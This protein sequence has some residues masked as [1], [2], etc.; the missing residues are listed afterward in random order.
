M[1]VSI[2]SISEKQVELTVTPQN[3]IVNIV[4]GFAFGGSTDT[5]AANVG[6]GIGLYK[7]KVGS[8][9]QFKSLLEG[10]NIDITSGVNEVTISAITPTLTE[11][12]TSG[13]NAGGIVISNIGAPVNPSDAVRLQD[14][15]AVTGATGP[16]GGDLTGTYPD[17]TLIDIA[18]L[19]PGIY[20]DGANYAAVEVDA[21][22]RVIAIAEF[23]LPSTAATGPAGGDL[24]GTYP[25]PTIS[26]GAVSYSKLQAASADILLGRVG[27]AGTIQEIT[28]GPGLAFSG[29]A[30]SVLNPS[31]INWIVGGN[32]VSAASNLGT[33]SNF[34]LP[35]ITNNVERMRITA[36]GVIQFSGVTNDD[37][38]TRVLV[39]DGSGNMYYRNAGSIVSST[40]TWDL[41]G[42]TVTSLVNFGTI[43]NFDIPIVTNNIE[44]ARFT[45]D[46]NLGLGTTPSSIDRLSIVG[47]ASGNILKLRDSANTIDRLLITDAGVIT[48]TTPALN[49]TNTRILTQ[50]S[51]SGI[52]EYRDV[53]TIAGGGGGGSVNSVAGT[54]N[55]IDIFGTA[56]DPV[57]D[58]ASTYVGQ[59]TI[60]TLGTVGTGTWE[61]DVVDVIYGGTGLSTIGTAAQL[62]RVNGS[63]TALEYFTPTFLTGNQT[64]TLTGDVTG[65]GTIGIATTLATNIVSAAKFRQSAAL[66]VVGNGTN[67]TANV[68]DITA[69]TDYNILRRTGTAVAF[70]TIDLSQAGAVG[71]SILAQA[72]GGTGLS[73]LLPAQRTVTAI[74]F[75]RPATYGYTTAETG[76]ITLNSTGFQ[77]NVT[78]LLIHNHTSTPTFDSN[79]VIIGGQYVVSDTNYIY[80]HAVKSNLILATISQEI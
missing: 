55:R 56:S 33:T 2:I 36:A 63:A 67:A 62:L 54:T 25:D 4:A 24:T 14:L 3:P 61:A 71:S 16:A 59:T 60:T 20:G 27:S 38:Q 79:F 58:I 46:G 64:I 23:P 42:S 11:V 13:A 52:V 66:S 22:G 12:L 8:Q 40:P 9:L 70:G 57:I 26:I 29:G 18:G 35:I 5:S 80:M 30:L 50:N 31:E 78:Q 41:G 10:S 1:S 43:D 45:T 77:E 19:T 34:D 74:Q 53:S 28:L 48:I 72:N 21:K 47:V 7:Q 68:T 49:N 39:T 75:D 44:I 17:P 37:T 73:S 6:T 69:G 51:V 15:T 76:N 32:N 65:S